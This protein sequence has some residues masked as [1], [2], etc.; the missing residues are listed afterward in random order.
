MAGTM[1]MVMIALAAAGAWKGETVM[2]PVA[3]GSWQFEGEMGRRIDG[4]VAEWLLRAPGANPG[5]IEMFHRR[6]R[7]LPY[8]EPV[9]WAGEFAGKYLIS[10]VQACRMSDDPGLRAFTQQF[11]DELVACQA[12]DGYL[13]PWPKDQRLLGHW[14]LW[15]HYHCMLGLLKWHEDTGD[16]KAWECVL[17]AAD[18]ICDIYAEGER[19]PIDAGTPM[20]NLAALHIFSLLYPRTENPRYWALMQRIEEDMQKDGDWL[21]KGADAV[22]YYQLP[23]GGTRWESLHIV[24]GFAELY[25]ITGEE[26][27]KKAL[28]SL[29]QSIR[30]FDRHPS[31]AFSTNEQAFGSV[32]AKGA[33]ETCCSVAWMALT[34]DALRLTGDATI[35]DELELTLWN[36]GLAQQH[37]SGNWCTYD[38]PLNG[39]RAPSYHQINFQYRPGTPELNCCSV[40][41]PRMFGMLSEWAVMEDEEG[42]AVNYYG[43]GEFS[44]T[45]RNGATLTL[46]EETQYP[47]DGGVRVV[48]TPEASAAFPVRFRIPAWSKKTT[49]TLNGTPVEQAPGAGQYLSL[50]RTWN[51]G[52]TVELNFDM[53]PR[54]WPGRGPDRGGCAAIHVGPLL[55]AFDEYFNDLELAQLGRIDMLALALDPVDFETPRDMACFKPMGL[56]KATTGDGASVR[57]C[58]FGSAGA[59]G[60]E[61]AAWLPASGLPPSPVALKAPA[62][63]AV[64]APGPV[65]LRWSGTGDPDTAYDVLV[66]EDAEFA[67]VV[68][69]AESLE[70][71]HVVF[72]SEFGREGT[73]FWKVISR[74]AVGSIENEDGPRRFRIDATAPMPFY[75]VAPDG[76]MAS[77]ALDGNGTPTYGHCA[78]EENLAPAPDRHGNEGGAVAFKAGSKLRY[79]LPFFPPEACTFAAWVCPEGLPAQGLQQLFSAWCRPSDDPLRVTIDGGS[80]FARMEA[81]GG[82]STAGVPLVAGEWIHVA[83]VKGGATVTLYVNGE[84]KQSAAAPREVNTLSAE[85]GIGFNPLYAGGEHFIGRMDDFAFYGRALSAEEIRAL[86]SGPPA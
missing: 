47:V 2:E 6:D 63:E 78:L 64:A 77:S 12:E 20:I 22:P 74:N 1:G 11:V 76:R 51:P 13:G 3:K 71:S 36:Q 81:P 57:L 49:V 16:E 35:A 41:G 62:S 60:T 50:D 80:L 9:P 26:R 33:I 65:C 58:D 40:N 8:A 34:I 24:Q 10:A 15:G 42:I 61:F 5:L 45:R 67:K 37:P 52:D 46:R 53:T 72:E 4:N 55:L 29:W 82:G 23:G 66:A 32:Y 43:P 14:D 73:Y 69:K 56:W 31:G 70:G 84:S 18:C 83:A 30:E 28:L 17:R 48:V 85:I 79:A 54:V 75:A 86:S 59:H 38:N 39:V 7:H 44:L 25:R 68:A 21:R 19:R 27:Y